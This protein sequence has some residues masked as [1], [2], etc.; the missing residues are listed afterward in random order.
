MRIDNTVE[1]WANDLASSSIKKIEGIARHNGKKSAAILGSLERHL[2][3]LEEFKLY[4]KQNL[5]DFQSKSNY[6]RSTIAIEMGVLTA[7]QGLPNGTVVVA[8]RNNSVK[9]YQERDGAWVNIESA[10]SDYKIKGM[11]FNHKQ[12]LVV[13]D[14]AMRIT[15]QILDEHSHWYTELIFK[16]DSQ[17]NCFQSLPGDR[18]VLG[19]AAGEIISV[20]GRNN[21]VEKVGSSRGVDISCLQAMP[22]DRI[23]FGDNVGGLGIYF[24]DPNQGWKYR[25]TET[26]WTRVNC[27]AVTPEMRVYCAG[28]SKNLI[29][30]QLEND[31]KFV[32]T[33][34]LNMDTEIRSIQV[35]PDGQLLL[36]G[37]QDKY[38]HRVSRNPKDELAIEEVLIGHNASV[39]CLHALR[40][41]RIISGS[42]NG[43]VKIWD[44]TLL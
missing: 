27:L 43:I 5:P 39:T 25:I 20:H 12:E 31:G 6:T 1:T 30:Y 16:G 34:E 10:A 28:N 8:S 2:S 13:V 15:K 23:I 22:G 21:S 35:L 42:I 44:G 38:V 33:N 40:D 7:V 3:E 19:T 36:A 32:R 11:H 24:R 29:E 18:I 26:P 4:D 41:G 37:G 17:I 9:F 14:N